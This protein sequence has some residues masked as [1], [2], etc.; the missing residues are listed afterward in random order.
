MTRAL[1]ANDQAGGVVAWDVFAV[2]CAV[3]DMNGNLESAFLELE[4]GSQYVSGT[5]ATEWTASAGGRHLKMYKNVEGAYYSEIM[6]NMLL[7]K[8]NSTHSS[9]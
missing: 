2:W 4:Q 3:Q 8:Y 1:K 7:Q 6:N 9:A 5:G